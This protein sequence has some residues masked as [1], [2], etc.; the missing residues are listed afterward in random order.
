METHIVFSLDDW[1]NRGE[2]WVRLLHEIQSMTMG[3]PRIVL[4]KGGE[5]ALPAEWKEK[6]AAIIPDVPEGESPSWFPRSAK[7]C[8][9]VRLHPSSMKEGLAQLASLI[10]T[11]LT[12]GLV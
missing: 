12:S 11:S 7:P 4:K 1:R 2:A 3:V 10:Q 8:A 5:E 6:F 9:I